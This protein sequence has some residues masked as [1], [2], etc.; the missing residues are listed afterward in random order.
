MLMGNGI[1]KDRL[2]EALKRKNMRQ[3]DLVEQTGID[4]SQISSYL[5]G[6]YKPKQENL[7]LMAEALEVREHWL[8]GVDELLVSE[9]SRKEMGLHLQAYAKYIYGERELEKLVVLYNK[10]S[11]ENRE[12][13]RV[14]MERMMKVQEME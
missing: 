13:T 10:L 7:T 11:S 4:K 14:Y 1:M 3:A 5:A 9:E 6:K 2:R 8:L 12:K